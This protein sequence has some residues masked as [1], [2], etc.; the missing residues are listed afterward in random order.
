MNKQNKGK[1]ISEYDFNLPFTMWQVKNDLDTW[2]VERKTLETSFYGQFIC[3]FFHCMIVG[4]NPLEYGS[5]NKLSV[6]LS[7]NDEAF[8][9]TAVENYLPVMEAKYR[10]KHGNHGNEIDSKKVKA[11]W[12]GVHEPHGWNYEAKDHIDTLQEKIENVRK[13]TERLGYRLMFEVDLCTKLE[14]KR[15]E[16]ARRRQSAMTTPKKKAAFVSM[17]SAR[18][19]RQLEQRRRQSVQA[20]NNQ[21]AV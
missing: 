15:Q 16:E 12:T 8:L 9:I 5:T 6:M 14:A 4:P 20:A 18:K 2:T 17:A 7:A 10:E 1:A 11:K 3:A 13:D 19:K 21:E